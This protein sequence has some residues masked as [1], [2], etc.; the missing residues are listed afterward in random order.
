MAEDALNVENEIDSSHSAILKVDT[1]IGNFQISYFIKENEDIIYKKSVDSTGDSL[2]LK[3]LDRSVFL[4]LKQNNNIIFSNK[5]IQKKDF[6]SIISC[7]EIK[8]YQLYSFNI[9]NVDEHNISFYVNICIPDTDL[10][11]LIELFISEDGKVTLE[12]VSQAQEDIFIP[13]PPDWTPKIHSFVLPELQTDSTFIENLNTVLF[14][15][16]DA[17]INSHD[18]SDRH[19][20]IHFDKEDSLNYSM[21]VSLWKTPAEKSIGFC[22]NNGFFYWLGGEVPPNII[23]GTKSKKRF[24]YE[25]YPPMFIDPLFWYLIYNPQTGN[26][27]VKE[28]NFY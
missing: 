9:K 12:E 20:C 5:E 19:F 21:E 25:E 8:K 26:I 17:Y 14:D 23:L 7:E 11:Y 22:E 18:K 16:N 1:V 4:S 15:K 2:L 10:C 24:S 28:K 27:E 13:S 3:Y 6:D